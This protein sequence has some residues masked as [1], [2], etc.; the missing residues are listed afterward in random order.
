[1]LAEKSP[2]LNAAIARL[3]DLNLDPRTIEI[4]ALHTLAEQGYQAEFDL[5]KAESEREGIAKG[6]REYALEVASKLLR[7]K[8]ALDFVAKITGLALD[9]V[10]DLAAEIN[11]ERKA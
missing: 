10:Q 9:E 4:A 2:T 11:A 5:A 3:K 7:A 8:S 1:M 6:K